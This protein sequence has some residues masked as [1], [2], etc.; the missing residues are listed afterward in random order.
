MKTSIRESAGTLLLLC[1]LLPGLGSTLRAADDTALNEGQRFYIEK[2]RPILSQKCYKCHT[3]QPNSRFRV[4]SREAILQGGKRG[5]SIVPGDPDNSLL[6]QAVRQTGELKMPKDSKLDDQEVADLVAWVKMGAPWDP[7]DHAKPI[8]PAVSA[9]AAAS[10]V[11]EDFFETKIRPIFAN[12]CSNCHD[13]KA[14]SGLRVLSRED[15]AAGRTPRTS[16]R[17]Q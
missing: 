13:D 3:D 15:V 1:V 10:S 17:S 2:I 5:P 6:I 11:G 16:H 7:L 8:I 12:I 4:D 9:A 14:T